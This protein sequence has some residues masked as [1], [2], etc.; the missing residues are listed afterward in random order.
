MVRLIRLSIQACLDSVTR[1]GIER[2]GVGQ[3][4]RK[5]VTT[6]A[7]ALM[8]VC[9]A[10][11][12]WAAAATAS[13]CARPADMNALRTAA[14][15]QRLMVAALSCGESQSYNS[16]VR[17]Y[18]KELQASDKALQNYFRRVNAK[19]G[20]ADYHAYKTRLANASSMAVIN[21]MTGYCS[22]A[23]A[24]FEQ[25][26]NQKPALAVFT[27]AATVDQRFVPCP[28]QTVSTAKAAPKKAPAAPKAQPAQR[29]V[30][31]QGGG[32]AKSNVAKK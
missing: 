31:A 1:S 30:P 13:G 15:Q 28:V 6:S 11:N 3:S 29:T 14:M 21:D 17:S 8:L 10:S 7:T 24:S 23:K 19:T 5:M 20:T 32:V 2:K 27:S 18:Q 22:S 12:V 26:L 25:A 4:M 9:M 16:F